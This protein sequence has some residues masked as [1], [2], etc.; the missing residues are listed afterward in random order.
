M[1]PSSARASA[2][3]ASSSGSCALRAGHAVELD[4]ADGAGARTAQ[5]VDA[6]VVDEPQQP[7]ARLEG[8]HPRAHRRVH[9]QEHV[10]QHVVGVMPG[11][12]QQPR[13]LPAQDG[14]VAFIHDRE[15]LFVTRGEARE[16]GAVL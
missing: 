15:R 13:R 7:R 8:H 11:G 5:L 4:V 14:A 6:R 9:A 16:E 3:R 2:R 12:V 1:S 10:L